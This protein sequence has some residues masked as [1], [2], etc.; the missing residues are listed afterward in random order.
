[1]TQKTKELYIAAFN[2]VKSLRPNFK[3]QKVMVDF[4]EASTAAIKQVFGD[5]VQIEGCWFHFSQA[6]VR[7]AKKI[8]L[9]AAYKNDEQ[10]N[11]CIRCLTCL[12]LL[13]PNDIPVAVTEL[14]TLVSNS[15]DPNKPLL[16]VLLKY[17]RKSWLSKSTIGPQR[18]SVIDSIQRTNNGV[19]SFHSGFQRLVKVSHP[20]IFSFLEHLKEVSVSNM[21]DVQRL[22]RAKQIRRPK[23]KANLMNDRRIRN[24]IEKY[25]SGGFSITQFLSSVS[26]C[27][28]SVTTPLQHDGDGSSTDDYEYE[29]DPDDNTVDDTAAPLPIAAQVLTCDVCLVAP[30][31][32][33][34]IVPCGHATFCKPC[35]DRLM[36]LNGHC[37][38]CRS[39]VATTIQFYN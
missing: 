27:S 13:P 39:S 6:V 3:P 18:L 9:S 37:P 12:P 24:S 36:T 31:D 33:I 5:E 30:R 28:E 15:A 26:H 25:K 1:M 21:A 20:G 29:L 17:V 19:E 2:K 14:E 16:D 38:L 7:K 23:K 32:K 10:A 4:E 11:K 35:I 8:G 34:A 22:N